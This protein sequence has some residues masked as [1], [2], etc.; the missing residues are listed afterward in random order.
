[1]QNKPKCKTMELLAPAGTTDRGGALRADAVFR[2]E[3]LTPA[4]AR[5]NFE[6]ESLRKTVAFAIC[7]VPPFI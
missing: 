2:A 5:K 1:M 6:L 4:E 3:I 7:T